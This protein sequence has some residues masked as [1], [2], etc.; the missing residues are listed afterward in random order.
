MLLP[1]LLLS[2]CLINEAVYLQRLAELT[3]GDGDG[4]VAEDDCD[5]GQDAVFPG[6]PEVCNERDDNCDGAVDDQPTDAE[7]WF[8]D[9][10]GDGFGSGEASVQACT[11]PSGYLAEGGDCDDD[12]GDTYPGATDEPYD[13]IDQDCEGG[14]LRDVDGDEADSATVGGADCNDLDPS[15]GPEGAET[16]FDGIDQDCDGL[17]L[18][19]CDL[20]GHS[21]PS[22]GGDD[23]DDD[24]ATV[25]PEAAESWQDAGVDNDCDGRLDDVIRQSVGTA[26]VVIDPPDTTGYTGG[27]VGTLPDMDGDGLAEVW[28]TAPYESDR[29]GKGG[30]LYIVPS[31]ALNPGVVRVDEA[32]WSIQGATA[33]AYF[34]SGV[35]IGELDG[36]GAVLIGEP[37]ADS[38]SGALWAV[39]PDDLGALGVVGVTDLGVA[40]VEGAPGDYLGIYPLTGRDFD[41]DGWSTHRQSRR[42]ARSRPPALRTPTP[43]TPA[44][45]VS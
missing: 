32:G 45:R 24:D 4:Y 42:R 3:D 40:L 25:H 26:D 7:T 44:A 15:I 41:G 35:A 12:R 9:A 17:D 14:D 2:G 31:A 27:S 37:G 16:C 33:G 23:C 36:R 39:D 11:P 29:V 20:D 43:Q 1:T 8:L 18:Q 22:V 10:D 28:M 34:G 6:A 13:G 5:D 38:G 19:D 30:A 21:P